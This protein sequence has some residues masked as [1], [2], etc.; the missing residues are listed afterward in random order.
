M[1][2]TPRLGDHVCICVQVIPCVC[3]YVLW[4]QQRE[5]GDTPGPG[6]ATH[7]RERKLCPAHTPMVSGQETG[8]HAS[9]THTINGVMKDPP[10]EP[11]S[12]VPRT[13]GRHHTDST[14][15][16]DK[17][18]MGKTPHSHT[19]LVD[20]R[21]TTHTVTGVSRRE[22]NVQAQAVLSGQELTKQTRMVSTHDTHGTHMVSTRDTAHGIHGIDMMHASHPDGTQRT[23]MIHVIHTKH[24]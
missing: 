12:M 19:P 18:G 8:S 4:G 20:Q 1:L 5:E 2:G 21:R 9:D 14:H 23:R 7:D 13:H 17:Q 6:A 16:H 11:I 3:M 24:T 10:T 15:M 22:A